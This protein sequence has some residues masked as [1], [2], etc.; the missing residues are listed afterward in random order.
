MGER[1][2]AFVMLKPDTRMA[3]NDM[4]QGLK[5]LGAGVLLLPE[6]IEIVGE[7]PRTSV[8]KVDKKA[9]HQAIAE[10]LREEGIIS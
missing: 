7:L 6:R 8:G 1:A 9:L 3:F 2:C 4:I 5:D 10:K